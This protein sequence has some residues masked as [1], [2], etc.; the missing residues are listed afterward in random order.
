[1]GQLCHVVFTAQSTE[2]LSLCLL[3]RNTLYHQAS[4][5][6]FIEL[7]SAEVQ[8]KTVLKCA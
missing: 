1:M 2:K 5:L 8:R 6:D 4:N 7:E 3:N